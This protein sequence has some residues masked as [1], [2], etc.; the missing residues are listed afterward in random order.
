MANYDINPYGAGGQQPSDIGIVNDLVTGGA[1]VALSAGMGKKLKEQEDYVYARLQAVYA[2]LGNAAFWEGKTPSANI[3]PELDWGYPKH[4]VTLALSLTNA[5]VKVNGVT[6]SNG[7][8]IRAEEGSTLYL[9]IEAESGYALTSVTSSTTGAVVSQDLSTVSIVVGDSDAT[10]SITAVAAAAH[11]VT[12]NTVNC[13]A[14]P[15]SASVIHGNSF[16]CQL[17]A[18]AGSTLPATVSYGS[19]QTANVVDGS[20]TIASVTED[21]TVVA[22]AFSPMTYGTAYKND[23]TL[24]AEGVKPSWCVNN[25]YIA[26]PDGTTDIVWIYGAFPQ[27]TP[28]DVSAGEG[29]CLAFYDENRDWLTYKACLNQGSINGFRQLNGSGL[30]S[31]AKY[32]RASFITSA[33]GDAPKV[34]GYTSTFPTGIGARVNDTWVTLFDASQYALSE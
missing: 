25:E 10:L 30:P 7:D 27:D 6:K 22:E 23:G 2:A 24:Q 20:F 26:I 34:W 17:T 13:T 21:I 5:V 19:G 8:T 32:V 15:A 4:N 18:A 12:V 28:A 16:T 1:N 11:Q 33:L 9:T 29:N 3:L 31:T 14:S